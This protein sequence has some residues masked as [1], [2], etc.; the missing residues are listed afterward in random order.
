MDSSPRY[1]LWNAIKSCTVYGILCCIWLIIS[2]VM[3]SFGSYHVQGACNTWYGFLIP[4]GVLFSVS[5]IVDGIIYTHYHPKVSICNTIVQCRWLQA[6]VSV[7]YMDYY[8]SVFWSLYFDHPE[9]STASWI[10][11][12]PNWSTCVICVL[13]I[14]S[15]SGNII[16][17]F[18]N[19]RIVVNLRPN[20]DLRSNASDFI[21][22]T[23]Q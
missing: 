1:W 23:V 15:Q 19:G 17:G 11:R 21:T 8:G 20:K 16:N 10:P 6:W 5:V 2:L 18:N 4:F 3:H 12:S 7:L 13:L 22:A 9:S 14:M